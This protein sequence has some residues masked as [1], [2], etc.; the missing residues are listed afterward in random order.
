MQELDWDRLVQISGLMANN[1]G[2]REMK[3][4]YELWP[5]IPHFLEIQ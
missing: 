3:M 1:I 5:E 4:L 2:I